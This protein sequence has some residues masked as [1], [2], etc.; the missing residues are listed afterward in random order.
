MLF[1]AEP[2]YST[3]FTAQAGNGSEFKYMHGL[4]WRTLASTPSDRLSLIATMSQIHLSLTHAT[5]PGKQAQQREKGTLEHTV[6]RKTT[7]LVM[8][9][10]G[11]DPHLHLN[12]YI[13][14]TAGSAC[15][16]LLS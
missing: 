12:D 6:A 2:V 14:C 10:P 4:S 15:G 9:T 16:L 5:L 11:T 7:K 3:D 8:T 13:G 1:K